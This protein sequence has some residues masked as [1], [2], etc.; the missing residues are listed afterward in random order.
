M[1]APEGNGSAGTRSGGAR[2]GA[3]PSPPMEVI[4][5][6]DARAGISTQWADHVRV[7]PLRFAHRVD[8][9]SVGPCYS[10]Q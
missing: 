10:G 8:G 2:F 6:R 7:V 5:R 9:E 3:Q 4:L 1:Q